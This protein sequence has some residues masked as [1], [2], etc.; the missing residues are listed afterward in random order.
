MVVKNI[1]EVI[2]FVT[3]IYEKVAMERTLMF[4]WKLIHK[5]FCLLDFNYSEPHRDS[6]IEIS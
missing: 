3:R 2:N 5:S 6:F 1:K 4:H